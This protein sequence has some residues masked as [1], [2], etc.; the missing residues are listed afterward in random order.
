MRRL[1]KPVW[2]VSIHTRFPVISDAISL[3]EEAILRIVLARDENHLN[4]DNNNAWKHN[5][6]IGTYGR[7]ATTGLP[8]FSEIL[9]PFIAQSPQSPLKKQ[10]VS[11]PRVTTTTIVIISLA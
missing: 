10:V 3:I 8:T 9:T 6:T 1:R 11:Q 5:K 2:L 4:D 7:L